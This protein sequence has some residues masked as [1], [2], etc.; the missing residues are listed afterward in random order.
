MPETQFRI[1]HP[2]G[3][4]F[5]V[6]VWH[7]EGE[8]KALVLLIHGLS[9]HAG[10]YGHVGAFFAEAGYTMVI[11]DLRGHGRSFGQRGHFPSYR[12][13]MDDLTLFLEEA[14]KRYPALPIFLYGHSMGGNLVLNYLIR[15]NPALAGAVVTSPWLRL[16]FKPGLFKALLAIAANRVFPS[17]S[18][19]DGIIPSYLSHDEAVVARYISDPLVHHMIS[20]RTFIEIS[21]AGE[22]AIKHAGKVTSPLLLMH[23]TG[24]RL[25]SFEASQEFS[26]KVT[27][28]ITFKPW[29]GLYHELHNE[30]EKDKILGYI[31][32]WLDDPKIQRNNY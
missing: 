16:N 14:R 2:E 30:I 1:P 28:N 9:D 26:E 6:T 23:G 3:G 31:P 20:V 22:Y 11:P 17:M 19:P 13:V 18:R 7:P 21:R 27:A 5:T 4:S 32:N 12:A 29:E 10:R 24:D 15:N 25:T 8:S